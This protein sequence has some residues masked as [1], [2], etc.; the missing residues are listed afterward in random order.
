MT[1]HL[2][3]GDVGLI[4]VQLT[5]TQSADYADALQGACVSEK[6]LSGELD[7]FDAYTE[8]ISI[9]EQFTAMAWG[10]A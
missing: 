2:H 6:Y 9:R 10:L 7:A 4:S 5:A 3:D 1:I 8:L